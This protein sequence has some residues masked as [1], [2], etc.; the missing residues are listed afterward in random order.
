MRLSSFA[1][2]AVAT[3]TLSTPS[4]VTDSGAVTAAIC[5]PTRSG[6]ASITP[7]CWIRF[8]KPDRRR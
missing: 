3:R 5:G 6:H 2:A 1:Q 8:A 4:W 7:A